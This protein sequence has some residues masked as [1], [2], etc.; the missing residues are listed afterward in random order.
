MERAI[1]IGN[2]GAGKSTFARALRD[3]TGLPLH[4]LDRLWHRPD[5]TTATREE[6]DL[7]LGELLAGERW[8]IDGNYRRTLEPRLAACDTVFF[9]DYPLEVCL[10]GVE[11]RRGTVR[12]DMPWIETQ[13]DPE[14]TAWIRDFARRDLPE[15]EALLDRYR[16][17]RKILRFQSRE[18]GQKYLALLQESRDKQTLLK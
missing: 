11:A 8:I 16:A 14:F 9:L 13:E 2:S 15:I 12:E 18:E 5:K 17:S 4:Y 6:F 1:V 10:A 7:R 3:V